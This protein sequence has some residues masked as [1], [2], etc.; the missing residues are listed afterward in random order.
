MEQ[1]FRVCISCLKDPGLISWFK[2]QCKNSNRGNCEFCGR[3]NMPVMWSN[4]VIEY[5]RSFIFEGYSLCVES[6]PYIQE[7]KK[8]SMWSGT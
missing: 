6:A 1:D 2:L 3:T 7:W 5:L 8:N 4:D